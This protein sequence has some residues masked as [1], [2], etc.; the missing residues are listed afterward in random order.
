MENISLLSSFLKMIFALALVLGLMIGVMYFVK[1]F[2]QRSAPSGAQPDLINI[3]YSKYL[4][5]K[6]SIILLEV[7]DQ[8]IV[9]GISGQQMTT[10]AHIDD[11]LFVE[12]IKNRQSKQNISSPQDKISK[13]LKLAG[14][15][16]GKKTDGAGK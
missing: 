13:L 5:P 4:G 6:S 7:M 3:L 10:L 14:F 11:P 1:N 16:A 2:M 15:P 8:L 12:K 9:V